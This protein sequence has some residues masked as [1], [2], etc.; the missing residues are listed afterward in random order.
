MFYYSK[1]SEYCQ[2]WL[3]GAGSLCKFWRA[4]WGGS[5]FE[6]DFGVLVHTAMP[7]TPLYY[8]RS[9][10]IGE[11][12]GTLRRAGFYGFYWS[13]VGH[14]NARVAYFL[15][16]TSSDVFPSNGYDRHNAFPVR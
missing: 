7:I 14:S 4:F 3:I 13:Q 6:V 10:Y 15:Y 12:Y 11:D 8:V 16:F 1:F 5:G 2:K 9:G